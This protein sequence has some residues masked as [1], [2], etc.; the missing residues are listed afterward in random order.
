MLIDD[1]RKKFPETPILFAQ[2]PTIEAFPAFTKE[3]KFVLGNHKDILAFHLHQQ[4]LKNKNI[5]FPTEK[6]N[7]K[8]WLSKLK[9][10]ETT[11]EFFSD[12]IHPSELCY[13]LWPKDG[14]Q[15]LSEPNIIFS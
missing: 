2:L 10:G 1:L 8:E 11:S 13:E 6:I 12:G 7:V 9:E 15:F 3:M 5:Y 14:V 4:V